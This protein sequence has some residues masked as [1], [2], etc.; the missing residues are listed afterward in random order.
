MPSP[1]SRGHTKE[2]AYVV[3]DEDWQPHIR[4]GRILKGDSENEFHIIASNEEDYERLLKKLER[5][6]EAQGKTLDFGEP[7]VTRGHPRITGRLEVRPWLWRRAFAKIALAAGSVAY[8]EDWRTSSDAEQ[9][10][11]WMRDKDA[12][13]YDYCPLERVAGSSIEPLVAPSHI[14][15]AFCPVARPR[16]LRRC[17]SATTTCACR[18]TPPVGRGRLSR[19][20]W[21]PTVRGRMAKRLGTD[22]SKGCCDVASRRSSTRRNGSSPKRDA[23][24]ASSL[25]NRLAS[26]IQMPGAVG[27][28]HWVTSGPVRSGRRT[29][30]AAQLSSMKG[31]ALSAA[32]RRRAMGCT[33]EGATCAAR[34]FTMRS[35]APLRLVSS[36]WSQPHSQ[37]YLR[38][39]LDFPATSV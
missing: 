2:G 8:D 39:A 22:S 18:W 28:R 33:A 26:T 10:R 13:P 21:I 36:V 20:T 17:F 16:N 27:S 12:L 32:S 24:H 15:C 31:R 4:G 3:A 23:I 19:G 25:S 37:R 1:F 29:D 7:E 38:P 11:R 34:V 35:G 6:A 30:T 9:L 14:S 5:D